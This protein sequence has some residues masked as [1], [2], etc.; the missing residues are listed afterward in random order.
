MDP[1]CGHERTEHISGDLICL[2][3]GKVIQSNSLLT[4]DPSV[5]EL[6]R[7][8]RASSKLAS[9]PIQLQPS[10]S[11]EARSLA[12]LHKLAS[13]LI[14]AFAL[15]SGYEEE[16]FLLMKSYWES[17]KSSQKF[18]KSGQRLLVAC[19]FLLA[20]RDHL[21][22]SFSALAESIQATRYECGQF[23]SALI[24]L[25]PS[26]RTLSDPSDFVEH[27]LVT[28]VSQLNS[29]YGL[30]IAEAKI[31]ELFVEAVKVAS[32]IND[33][34][35]SVSSQ[36]V[37]LASSWIVLDSFLASDKV[38]F[39]RLIKEQAIE[40][41]VKDVTADYDFISMRS[42]TSK[43]NLLIERLVE[44]GKACL[45]ATFNS[46]RRTKPCRYA[47]LLQYLKEILVFCK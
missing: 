24:Q 40:K 36:S 9:I 1:T 20:R 2:L 6:M 25:D 46:L 11:H 47:L 4:A 21:A 13:N 17:V 38:L 33:S 23:S 43:R 29:R 22:V 16:A 27:E 44:V 7:D 37:A 31:H 35:S 30:V 28:L 41:V 19:L 15:K 42:V 14:S 3:C 8:N 26:L 34:G 18:G 10:L 32:L 12:D 39:D 45:P 5:A